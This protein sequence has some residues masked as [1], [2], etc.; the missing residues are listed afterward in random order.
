ME[1]WEYLNTILKWTEAACGLKPLVSATYAG[2]DLWKLEEPITG[3][4]YGHLPGEIVSGEI[5]KA[6]GFA[7]P[8]VKLP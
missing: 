4:P 1:Q 5:V 8:N 6:A 3:Q 7:L 2:D